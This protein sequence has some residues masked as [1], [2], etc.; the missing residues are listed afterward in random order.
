MRVESRVDVVAEHLDGDGNA[1][2][3]TDGDAER[4]QRAVDGALVGVAETDA[5]AGFL[6][7]RRVADAEHQ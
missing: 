2:A 5:G 1:G 4:Q 7:Q 3:V 6:H